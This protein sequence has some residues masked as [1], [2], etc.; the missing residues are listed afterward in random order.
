MAQYI[1]L[2]VKLSNSRINKLSPAIKKK[3]E[4]VLR[5]SW[6]MIC[7]YDNE[8]NFLQKLL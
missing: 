1:S 3:E 4:R 7:I 8:T 6:N 5:L 2:N